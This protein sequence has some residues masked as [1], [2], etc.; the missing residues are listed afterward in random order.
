MSEAA[1]NC[2]TDMWD[3]Y[4]YNDFTGYG[5]IELLENTVNA[6]EKEWKKARGR[7]SEELFWRVEA[8][9]LFL[10]GGQREWMMCDDGER[11]S[12]LRR[13]IASMFLETFLLLKKDNLLAPDSP[14]KNIGFVAA[15]IANCDCIS[16]RKPRKVVGLCEDAGITVALGPEGFEYDDGV[17]L[18]KFAAGDDDD[19]DNG[20]YDD[21]YSDKDSETGSE[22]ENGGFRKAVCYPLL[23]VVFKLNKSAARRLQVHCRHEQARRSRIQPLQMVQ[24]GAE[25]PLPR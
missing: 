23:I 10:F 2:C 9:A 5:E 14:L 25:A 20:D 15:L 3:V 13:L 6:F 21:G 22:G 19:D 11:V 1:D 16:K 24:G 17:D 12:A 18:T 4:I 7:K 8:L